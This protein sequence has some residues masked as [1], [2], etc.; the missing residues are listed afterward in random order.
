MRAFIDLTGKIFGNLTVLSYEGLS[1]PSSNGKQYTQWKCFCA[2]GSIKV[3]KGSLLR[4]GHAK[5]CGCLW[6][7]HKEEFGKQAVKHGFMAD[8]LRLYKIWQGMM[9]RCYSQKSENYSIYG[10]RGIKVT[11]EWHSVEA[12]C[13][14]ALSNG[15]ADNLTIDRKNNNEDYSP[16]NCHWANYTVQARNRRNNHKLTFDGKTLCIS[17]WAE[18]L[19]IR[20]E[21]I[22]SRLKYGWSIKDAL[23]MPINRRRKYK[24]CLL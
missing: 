6:E 13:K 10:G 8:H 5:S 18:I 17:E 15:Y 24:N 7:K 1:S 22:K 4:S 9:R 20:Q 19:D 14:W 11:D 2:C 21:S 23:T 12:F 3:I 16:D